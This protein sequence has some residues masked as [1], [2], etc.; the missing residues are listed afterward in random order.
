MSI[1]NLG[2]QS[3]GL[4]R[5][6]MEE[7]KESAISNCSSISE[8][9]RAAK[10]DSSLKDALLDSIALAKTTLTSVTQRLKLKGKQ[11]AVDV[12]AREESISEMW[13]CLEKIDPEFK[14]SHTEK[15]SH[16]TITPQLRKFISHCC[17]QRHYFFEIKKCGEAAC[18]ICTPVRML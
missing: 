7:E 4:A 15:V 10:E 8:I 13:S 17:S 14:L 5:H 6:Q 11:F 9:R 16:K 18:E 12:A 1:L 2:L 3:V